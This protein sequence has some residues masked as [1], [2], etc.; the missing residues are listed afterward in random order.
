[1]IQLKTTISEESFNQKRAH[2]YKLSIL[3]GVDSFLYVVNDHN[4]QLLLL[5]EYVFD[6]KQQATKLLAERIHQVFEQ[7]KLL[8]LP[9]ASV[10]ASLLGVKHTFIPN[11]LYNPDR[12]AAYLEHVIE[13]K[14]TDGIYADDVTALRA[15]NVYTA[16]RATVN[17]IGQM[18]PVVRFSH[19]SS[20]LFL[21]FREQARAEKTDIFLSIRDNFAYLYC[22]QNRELVFSNAFP[23]FSPKD[24]AYYVLLVYEQF[25]CSPTSQPLFVAGNFQEGSE[26]HRLLYR[27][28]KFIQPVRMPNYYTSGE[29]TSREGQHH[30]FFDLMCVNL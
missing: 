25:D 2:Q 15:Q 14:A 30:S 28:I 21:G 6:A 5:K 1:M 18:Y 29:K 11:R 7:D 10:K 8:R 4:Q 26:H 24:L 9:Y 19:I 16:D 13:L 3:A 23:F 20:T 17:F 22:F 12:K 27:Y